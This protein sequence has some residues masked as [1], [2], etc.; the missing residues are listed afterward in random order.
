MINYNR[1]AKATKA[2]VEHRMNTSAVKI[3]DIT[4]EE[5]LNFGIIDAGYKT[6]YNPGSHIFW[7]RLTFEKRLV[8]L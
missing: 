3:T 1:I 2:H 8:C 6:D 5:I 7:K 4:L